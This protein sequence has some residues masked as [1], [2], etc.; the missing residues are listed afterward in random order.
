MVAFGDIL[1]GVLSGVGQGGQDFANRQLDLEQ[2]KELQ[3][4][5][6]PSAA[7]KQEAL[8]AD[9][10]KSVLSGARGKRGGEFLGRFKGLI[11]ESGEFNAG[12]ILAKLLGK[13]QQS[14]APRVARPRRRN[15]RP[16][17]ESTVKK[18]VLGNKKEPNPTV[19]STVKKVIL[20]NKKEPLVF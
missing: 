20:G 6:Q 1:G 16:T 5:K 15:P 14:F 10:L 9:L 13:G 12:D 2:A 18:V 11:P 8:Q 3:K 7:E 17:V 4:L 19:E